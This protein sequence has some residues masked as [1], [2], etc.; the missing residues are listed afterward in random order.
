MKEYLHCEENP[1]TKQQQLMAGIYAL[2]RTVDMAKCT[3]YICH[4][5]R[6][7]PRVNGAATAYPSLLNTHPMI[8]HYCLYLNL[9]L[10]A[11]Q[12]TLAFVNTHYSHTL[13]LMYVMQYRKFM[14]HVIRTQQES[15]ENT[16]SHASVSAGQYGVRSVRIS[17]G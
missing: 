8:M 10:L 16:C 12:S 14:W 13:Q 6:V 2:W 11:L 1:H 9:S 17:L 3:K 15:Q 7:L 5:H 4:L